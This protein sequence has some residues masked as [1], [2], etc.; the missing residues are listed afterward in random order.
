MDIIYR[1]VVLHSIQFSLYFSDCYFYVMTGAATELYQVVL[2]TRQ[3]SD[4]FTQSV[5]KILN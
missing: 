4:I 1:T 3:F 5:M 2:C